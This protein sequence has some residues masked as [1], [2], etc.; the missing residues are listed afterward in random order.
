MLE[1][2]Y[3][4]VTAVSA[5]TA[6]VST[7]FAVESAVVVGFVELLPHDAIANITITAIAPTLALLKI[8][9]NLLALYNALVV[10]KS[11]FCSLC[12]VAA[13]FKL[14]TNSVT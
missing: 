4:L 8:V 14:F 13:S 12:V 9:D 10:K 7:C 5:F 2:G 1:V 11:R 6:V 3:Y